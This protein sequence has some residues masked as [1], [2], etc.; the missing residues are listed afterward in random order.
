MNANEIEDFIFG[1]YYKRTGFSREKKLLLTETL[2]KRNII[3][4]G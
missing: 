3:V 4:A 1:N 2:E